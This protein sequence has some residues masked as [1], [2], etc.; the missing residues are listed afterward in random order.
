MS[1]FTRITVGEESISANPMHATARATSVGDELT[2]DQ[3][4]RLLAKMKEGRIAQAQAKQK[5]EVRRGTRKPVRATEE[6]FHNEVFGRLDTIKQGERQ[7]AI[8]EPLSS[9]IG[10]DGVPLPS[11]AVDPISASLAAMHREDYDGGEDM[12]QYY[13]ERQPSAMRTSSLLDGDLQALSTVW[14]SEVLADAKANVAKRD[15]P[16][17][18][19]ASQER[20]DRSTKAQNDIDNAFA[21]IDNGMSPSDYITA[22]LTRKEGGHEEIVD[23][24]FG[25]T[26]D[27]RLRRVMEE[28][29][30]RAEAVANN[31]KKIKR[32]GVN[33]A[34]RREYW[35]QRQGSTKINDVYSNAFLLDH[36]AGDNG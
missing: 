9:W 24:Q 31:S 14:Q 8:Q 10:D 7:G 23:S 13:V 3:A 19:R 1:K 26:N 28:R 21:Q 5:Q 34:E 2:N 36:L 33:E 16:D 4:M 30:K 35:E 15:H 17:T 29:A 32:A 27:D 11:S 22:S 20:Q 6:Y 12:E 25:I 18:S